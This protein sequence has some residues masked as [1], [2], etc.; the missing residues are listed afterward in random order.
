MDWVVVFDESQR[1]HTRRWVNIPIR[2][3]LLQV[4]TVVDEAVEVTSELVAA[5]GWQAVVDEGL[6]RRR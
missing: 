1:W 6:Q 3:Q 2:P 5:R 4:S